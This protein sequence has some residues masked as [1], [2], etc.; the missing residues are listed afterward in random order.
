[1]TTE[2]QLPAYGIDVTVESSD[3]N[4]LLM[5]LAGEGEPAV[6]FYNGWYAFVFPS[7]TG[8]V[9][10]DFGH[11]T[12]LSAVLQLRERVRAAKEGA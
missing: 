6:K 7:N 1:M 8:L 12:P 9:S 5:E 11:P 2:I 4:A 10:S 3:L